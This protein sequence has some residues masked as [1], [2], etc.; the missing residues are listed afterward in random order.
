M[1]KPTSFT[2]TVPPR[3]I[4]FTV[5]IPPQRARAGTLQ[6]VIEETLRAVNG[7][8]S[9]VHIDQLDDRTLE[10][11]VYPRQD[12]E[13]EDMIWPTSPEAAKAFI[14]LITKEETH[15]EERDRMMRHFL[16]QTEMIEP[17][18]SEEDE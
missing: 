5:T 9:N 12:W 11:S 18:P 15:R 6:H 16:R 2:V 3:T 17:D 14:D 7:Y 1:K 4:K 10:I 8:N 13:G